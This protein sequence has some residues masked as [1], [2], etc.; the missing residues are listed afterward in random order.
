MW[1]GGR[2]V[3]EQGMLRVGQGWRKGGRGGAVLVAEGKG[4]RGQER[5]RRGGALL[6]ARGGR[7][8]MQ[9]DQMGGK[10]KGAGWILGRGYVEWRLFFL[11]LLFEEFF[12]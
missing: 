2:K 4:G 5:G 10:N 12:S 9:C 7:G 8:G 6:V 1:W 3:E 11:F